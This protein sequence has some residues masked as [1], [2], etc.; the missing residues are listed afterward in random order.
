MASGPLSYW[1]FRETGPDHNRPRNI[2]LVHARG[3]TFTFSYIFCS[4]QKSRFQLSVGHNP[5]LPRF[6]F[7]S[8][9]YW[10]RLKKILV[11]TLRFHR[12]LEIFSSFMI[13]CCD[14]LGFYFTTLI[15]QCSIIDKK[16]L[17][18][19]IRKLISRVPHD[20][21]Y[22]AASMA[23]SH[24]SSASPSARSWGDNFLYQI[25]FL[26]ESMQADWSLEQKCGNLMFNS[27][28]W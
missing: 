19:L 4:S 6:F 11:L 18:Y 23:L 10:S 26:L 1:D 5:G 22:A 3:N 9:C 27:D 28:Q 12:L 8:L 16:A 7:T 20:K 2:R 13:G 21:L 15:P 14:Y 17:T 24:S 25:N